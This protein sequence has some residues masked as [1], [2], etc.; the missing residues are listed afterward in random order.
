MT[1][2]IFSLYLDEK[3]ASSFELGLIISLMSYTTLITQIP[4]GLISKRVGVWWIIPLAL[5]GQ[6]TSYFLY[7]LAPLPYFYPIRIFHAVVSASLQP[8]LLSYASAIVPENNRG[9][10]IGVYLTSVGLAM[11]SGPLINSVLLMFVG[12]QT[13][14]IIA[15]AIP[16]I[17]LVLYVY[18]LRVDVF[19]RHFTRTSNNEPSRVDSWNSL[20]TIF[21][22]R[23]VQALTVIRFTFAF[24]MSI[25]TTLYAIYAVNIL[26]ISPS[27]YAFYITL[28]GMANTIARFPTGRIT[29]VIG[30]KKPLL[31]SFILLS[32]VFFFLAELKHPIQ[33]GLLIFF[34]GISH[35]TRAVSEWSMLSD[36]VRNEDRELAHF[37][38][39]TV[40]SL[41]S[42]L[43][44]T[45]AGSAAMVISTPTI[46]QIAAV[47]TSSS[48][49]IVAITKFPRKRN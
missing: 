22:L 35:G 8:T 36:A 37:Y 16:L 21:M 39:S 33:V 6:S 42:A 18:L 40:F 3:G 12:Y 45:F 44:A 29:D 15:T 25:L 38:F 17:A 1:A 46:L 26:G 27:I 41:G 49:F 20:K 28:K 7:S 5:V 2:S 9:E 43:G 48:I 10:A 24:T 47:L 11:M 19:H 14:L 13:I 4:L 31:F 23:P 30:R 34:H 32:I